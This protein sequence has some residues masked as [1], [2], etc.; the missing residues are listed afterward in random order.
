MGRIIAIDYGFKR[1]GL[2]VTD[3]EKRIATPLSVI[4]TSQLQA[5][6]R[7]YIEE[8]QVEAIVLGEPV[9]WDGAETHT[10]RNIR[11]LK[12]SL[13]KKYPDK[14]V[15]MVDESFTS[16]RAR[17]AMIAGGMKKKGRRIKGNVDKISATLIL[18]AFLEDYPGM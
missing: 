2:A 10:S 13:E 18:Q 5:F 11:E 3:P 4:D 8:E 16:K 17:E 1:T 12:A 9:R 15:Y 14:E 7:K 6:L